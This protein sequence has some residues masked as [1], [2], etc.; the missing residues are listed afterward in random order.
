MP[1]LPFDNFRELWIGVAGN[2]LF[3]AI[4]WLLQKAIAHFSHITQQNPSLQSR[5]R[6][7]A[8]FIFWFIFNSVYQYAAWPFPGP[9]SLVTFTILA[10]FL[11]REPNQFSEIGL[12]HADRS[13]EAGLGYD[14]SLKLCKNRLDFL[15]IGASKLTSS[16]EFV[17]AVTRCNRVDV[18][19]RFLLTK[20]N[21]HRLELAARQKGLDPVKYRE[22][23]E[24]S[25]RILQRLK[26][27]SGMNIEVRFYPSENERDMPLFRMMF[28]NDS[29]LLLS[30]NIFG[31]G[32]GSQLPQIHLKNFLDRR[33]V[34]SFYSPFS[35]YYTQLWEDSTSW[36]FEFPVK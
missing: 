4:T 22:K 33:N 31:E 15:G 29:I 30:Y 28:I 18:P 35:S 14:E 10:Y 27:S 9:T 25:L 34:E 12:I 3:A 20:P 2:A 23:V 11:W 5:L 17:P 6:I 1:S 26:K 8:I 16:S 19:I 21:N 13:V 32:D 36:D 24:D 7:L